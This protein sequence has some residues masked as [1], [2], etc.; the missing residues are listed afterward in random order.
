MSSNILSREIN[1]NDFDLI[2]AGAQK[3]IGPSGLAIV[4]VKKTL[5]ARTGVNRASIFDYALQA[6]KESMYNTPPT[7]SWYLA[8]EVFKWLKA[9]GGIAAIEQE[10][11]EKATL[12]YDFID[13]STFY[14]NTVDTAVRSRMNIPFWLNDESLNNAFLRESEAVG[15]LAL[16]GHRMVGGMRASSYNA[17]PLAGVKALVGFMHKFEKEHS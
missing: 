3:N 6:Q 4:I 5:L 10:N 16:A 9:Q 14:K 2:Y 15:L 7:Y 12:L 17:M 8:A 11:I 1:I 13:N